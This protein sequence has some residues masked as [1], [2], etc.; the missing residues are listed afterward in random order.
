MHK[1]T[2][3]IAAAEQRA[4]D[5]AAG[6]TMATHGLSNTLTTEFHKFA[7]T[8]DPEWITM[9]VDGVETIRYANPFAG[10][11]WYPLMNVAVKAKPDAA[12][13]DG[14]GE[15]MVRSVRIWR[16]T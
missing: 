6:Q 3:Q 13:A 15:M 9:Y 16:S 8:V 11:A 14:S 7:A 5:V 2:D 1:P 12:Y 10:R 4:R